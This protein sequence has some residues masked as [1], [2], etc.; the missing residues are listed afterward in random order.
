MA[1]FSAELH[2]SGE[3][4]PVTRCAFGVEQAT[5]QRGR[6]STK[7]R[8]GPV[9][10][11]LDVPDGETLF[12]WAA[13][14]QKRQPV[15][16][17][18][19]DGNGGSVLETLTLAAAYCVSYHEQF[20]HGEV[21]SGAYECY[22]TLSDPDGWTLTAG[23]PASALVAPAARNH[24][25]PG[26]VAA[27]GQAVGQQLGGRVA[28]KLVAATPEHKAARWSEYQAANVGNPKV[29]SEERWSK[30]YDTN[31]RNNKVGLGRER[32]YATAMDAVSKTLKTPLTYRQIDLY[33]EDERYCGQLKTGK[34]SLT[35]QARLEDIPKDAE[36]VKI[37]LSVEYILEKGASKPFLAALDAAG[38][39][40]KIGPQIP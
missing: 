25:V 14:A 16:V 32:E 23:G 6:V 19:R 34:M 31:M 20:R 18:F 7:V 36:L 10:L 8:F 33:I 4:F 29:W 17:F 22:L 1:S 9:Q 5:H 3:S 15:Q 27:V 12:G 26:A 35:K 40:Y 11:T 28:T 38:A 2:V 21:G 13:D 30:Q 24:G 39:T 37:G